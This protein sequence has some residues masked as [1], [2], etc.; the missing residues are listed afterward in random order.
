MDPYQL[1]DI[2]LSSPPE[3]DKGF[4]VIL[5][6]IGPPFIGKMRPCLMGMAKFR[7]PYICLVQSDVHSCHQL[8]I[9]E[10]ICLD[11]CFRPPSCPE[12]NPLLRADLFPSQRSLAYSSRRLSNFPRVC[13][14]SRDIL[15]NVLIFVISP[16]RK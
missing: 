14:H 6:S 9:A 5:S 16:L 1:V 4:I 3:G 15:I 12:N 11:N 10:I 8:S 7:L 13:N 2:P